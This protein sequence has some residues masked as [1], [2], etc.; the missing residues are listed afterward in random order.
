MRVFKWDI[1]LEL[2]KKNSKKIIIRNSIII[3]FWEDKGY[4]YLY[5]KEYDCFRGE[6]W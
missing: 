5:R 1:K 3:F 4:F 2:G 6:V